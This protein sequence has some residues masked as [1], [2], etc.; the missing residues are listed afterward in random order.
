MTNEKIYD[1]LIAGSG[2]AGNV[3]AF[4]L[5]RKN[6][7]CLILEKQPF[8]TEKICGGGFSYKALNLLEE[9]GMDLTQ[10][11]DLEHKDIFGH[12]KFF[13][14]SIFEKHYSNGKV[15]MG[16]QRRLSDEFLLQ[17][18]IREGVKIFYGV[19]VNA[20]KFEGKIFLVNNQYAAK[21][22]VIATGARGFSK[23]IP[24]G[25]SFGFSAL[26]KGR[27]LLES[28]KFYFWY[29]DT[30]CDKYCWLFPIGHE[31]WNVGIWQR[32]PDSEMGKNFSSW[33]KR[34][35]NKY[36]PKGFE[37]VTRIRGSYLGNVDQRDDGI[38]S[39]GL[40]DFAG[41]N[42][43]LNGGGIIG[44]IESAIEFAQKF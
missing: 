21:N 10:L 4:L 16:I 25:Q 44:A 9:I 8:R 43:I 32:V 34:I 2:I 13:P 22:F 19:S 31:L 7:S 41:Y 15:S 36:F 14:E 28:D 30:S 3:C 5:A 29:C 26:I 39:N 6:K 23:K 24:Q 12:V 37:Y 18:A 40:G 11:K 1:F 38:F 27:S 35:T 33:L 17:Q 42:N 20:V